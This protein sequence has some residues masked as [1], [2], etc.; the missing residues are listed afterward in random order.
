MC[1][2]S[3]EAHALSLVVT[4]GK[5]PVYLRHGPVMQCGVEEKKCMS[6]SCGTCAIV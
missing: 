4:E 5:N 6:V 1:L 3:S 2:I